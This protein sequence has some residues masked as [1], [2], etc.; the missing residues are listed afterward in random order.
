MSQNALNWF[1]PYYTDQVVH[2]LQNTGF[3]LRGMTSEATEIVGNECHWR[4]AGAVAA[5]LFQRGTDFL[6]VAV[7]QPRVQRL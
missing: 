3:K 5:Q 1:Q 7:L 2:K 4:I 6:R